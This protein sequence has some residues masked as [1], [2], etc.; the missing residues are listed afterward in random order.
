[1]EKAS[2]VRRERVGFLCRL[3][4]IRC[5]DGMKIAVLVFESYEGV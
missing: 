2:F 3:L 5:R 4:W 1:M